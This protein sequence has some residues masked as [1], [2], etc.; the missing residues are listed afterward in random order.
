MKLGHLFSAARWR[1]AWHYRV[2]HRWDVAWVR[3]QGVEAGDG[4]RLAGRPKVERICGRIVLGRRVTLRSHDRG[5]HTA[6]YHPVRLMVDVSPDALIEI[7][8]DSRINGASIH[9]T[10]SIRIGRN[11]LIAAN[12]MILDSDG[13]GVAVADRERHNPVAAPI[14]IEDDVW[15]G[16]NAIVLKG[17]TLGRGSVVAAGSVVTRDVAPM[18]LV[19]GNP[20]RFIKALD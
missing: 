7:G 14:V 1:D 5:Y 2:Q 19:G 20:A 16:A 8:D 13:H 18:T 10:R 11:C 4:L 15:V 3:R 6:M 12:V 17:V 9:A